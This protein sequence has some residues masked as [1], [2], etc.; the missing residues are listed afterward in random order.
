MI[1][2]SAKLLTKVRSIIIKARSHKRRH[3][4]TLPKHISL[5]RK[6]SKDYFFRLVQTGNIINSDREI[7][8]TCP[9]DFCWCP[10]ESS[11]LAGHFVQQ[12]SIHINC[13]TRKSRMTNDI[14]HVWHGLEMSGRALKACR[15][16][17]AGQ[18]VRHTRNN[19]RDHWI[20]YFQ[21]SNIRLFTPDPHYQSMYP[22]ILPSK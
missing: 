8:R 6:G 22:L 13:L 2:C 5:F 10:A 14:P 9:A 21:F 12:G 20:N 16:T 3:G 4:Q 15:T 17:A 19:F 7:C 1:N 18:F 11:D